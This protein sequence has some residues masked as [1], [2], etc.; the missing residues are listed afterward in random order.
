LPTPKSNR[1]RQVVEHGRLGRQPQRMMKRQRIEVVAKPHPPRPLHR[2][3]ND[4]VGRRQQRTVGEMMF[5]EPALVE[6]DR[7]R[8]HDLLQHLRIEPLVAAHCPGSNRTARS[9]R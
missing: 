7:F 6:P 3:R 1:R 8:Q 2:R 4:Q 5:R 9:S